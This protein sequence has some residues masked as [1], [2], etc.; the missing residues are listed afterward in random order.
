MNIAVS[1]AGASLA[2][3]VF[4]EFSKTPFLLI[5]NVETMECTSI[6]HDKSGKN[7][8]IALAEMILKHRCEALITG[9]LEEDVFKILAD[10]HVTR[11]FGSGLSA[12][13]A[14][15]AMERRELKLIRNPEGTDECNENHHEL[16]ELQVCS[17]HQH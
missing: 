14:L 11:F 15:M 7:S 16:E 3:P 12:E 2:S 17:G 9:K 8:E 6:P 4:E 10:D 5:V 13:E 1:A